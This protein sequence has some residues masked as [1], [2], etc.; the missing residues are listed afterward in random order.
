MDAGLS[1]TL[2]ISRLYSAVGFASLSQKSINN[3]YLKWIAFI[4]TSLFICELSATK[5]MMCRFERWTLI[6]TCCFCCRCRVCFF[7]FFFHLR[8]FSWFLRARSNHRMQA[9]R[10]LILSYPLCLFI[11]MPF[12]SIQLV[13]TI[14]CG[15]QLMEPP[16][17][18]ERGV[19]I[20]ETVSERMRPRKKER[21]MRV[22]SLVP[23]N[24]LNWNSLRDE[25]VRMPPSQLR[26]GQQ[27]MH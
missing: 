6:W 11:F 2:C 7:S 24:C 26:A 21:P 22:Y 18:V 20:R 1:L 14:Y 16:T 23:S 3:F 8:Y 13:S 9:L 27:W 5:F 19:G 15:C 12:I 10:S 4:S 17:A 25:L